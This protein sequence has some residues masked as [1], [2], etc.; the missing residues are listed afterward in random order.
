MELIV[1][2]ERLR[3]AEELVADLKIELEKA[4]P[5]DKPAVERRLEQAIEHLEILRKSRIL[6]M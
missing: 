3:A 2:A 4:G 1:S 6:G 5:A